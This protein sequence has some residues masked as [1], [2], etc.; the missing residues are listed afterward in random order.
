MLTKIRVKNFKSLKDVTL[1]LGQ[2]NVLVGA[3]M[4]GK[5]NVIDLF[6]FVSQMTFPPAGAWALPNAVA[7][8]GGF[9]ELL[10]KGGHEQSI[11]LELV[12][13]D[14][15]GSVRRKWKYEILI[16]GDVRGNFQVVNETLSVEDSTTSGRSDLIKT[17]GSERLFLNADGG[18]IS[19]MNTP[20]RS[21]LEFEIPDWDGNFLRSIIASWRFYELIPPIMRN[22]NPAAAAI[23]LSEH[24]D[25]LSQWLLT[26]QTRHPESFARIQTVLRDALPQISSLFTSPTQQSTVVLGTNEKHLHRPVT[27]GQ[28][29]AGELVFIAYLSL[30]F[31]PAELTGALYCVEDIENHL[32][33]NLIETLLQVLRQSQ[34]Q[35]EQKHQAAQILVTTH[36]P[37]VVDKMK[38]DEVVFVERK[39]GATL[40]SRPGGK[41]HLRKLLEDEEVGLGDLVYSGALSDASK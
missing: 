27:L 11:S 17:K 21:M 10:W 36:S 6:K 26:L 29:S 15:N 7:I 37:A 18:L 5:S 38:L 39:D 8:R 19:S 33:P 40:C 1:E 23:F 16:Q 20:T 35:W 2:R 9:G 22:P 24:G 28:M 25:N 30:I 3:N 32:H 12:G 14:L 13:D 31:G 34:E 4:A 41:S